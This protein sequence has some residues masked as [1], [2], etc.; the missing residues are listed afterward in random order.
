[1]FPE[2]AQKG[3]WHTGLRDSHALAGLETCLVTEESQYMA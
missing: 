2:A 3:A 1:M